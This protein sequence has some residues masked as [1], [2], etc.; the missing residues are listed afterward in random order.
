MLF[1]VI[2]A[3]IW[4]RKLLLIKLFSEVLSH[5]F[6]KI[7]TILSILYQCLFFNYYYSQEYF[8]VNFWK[9]YREKIQLKNIEY[10]CYFFHNL[11]FKFPIFQKHGIPLDSGYSVAPHHSGVY[12][13]HEPLYEAWKRVWNVRVTSTEEYPHLRPARLRR[14]FIHR[15]IMVSCETLL[16][17][18]NF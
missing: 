1:S 13:V 10:S 18:F 7:W 5:F 15:N 11:P 9:K 2:I 12:P 16:F 17:A 6:M 8:F 14:G 3:C 4:R